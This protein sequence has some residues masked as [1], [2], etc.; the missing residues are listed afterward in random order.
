MIELLDDVLKFSFPGVH[1]E[2]GCRI[3]FRR[4]LRIPDD[5]RDYPLPPSLGRF[6]L[7]HVDDYADRLPKAWGRHGGVFFPMY[8]AEAMW[9]NFSGNYPCAVKIAA[10][11]VNAITGENWDNALA[12]KPQDYVV[13][14]MQPWLDGFNVTEGFIRQFVAM[15]LGDGFTAE[16]QITSQ[17]EHGGL[18]IIVYPM[19]K[20]IYTKYFNIPD[21]TD[22]CFSYS[23]S[24]EYS[25]D[26][27]L[28]PGGLMRQKIYKDIYGINAWDQDHASR[29]FVH[30]A[31]SEQYEEITGQQPPHNP[32]S[33]KEYTDAGM[34]WFE[35]YGEEPAL[36]GSIILG[37]QASVANKY[38]QNSQ[39][40]LPHNDS[41][42]PSA[43]N[44]LG[45]VRVVRESDF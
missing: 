25:P 43:I 20:D 23:L 10:G 40:A 15:P 12:N 29:V 35:Y 34:P 38:I 3:D 45:K 5:N 2:A 31:N 24:M 21:F 27:G 4:T 32:P 7:A 9:I 42:K 14:S 41:L 16:E 18:Q 1:P 36:P 19:K 44:A 6:P 8:Q 28:A 13:T 33:A 30:L 17:V 39:Q 37:S 22:M 11:K 26:M